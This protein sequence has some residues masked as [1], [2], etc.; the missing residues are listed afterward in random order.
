MST[1]PSHPTNADPNSDERK[2]DSPRESCGFSAMIKEEIVS[3]WTEESK[4]GKAAATT[5]VAH[6]LA[7]VIA[8][9]SLAVRASAWP[10]ESLVI[11]I[12]L[13]QAIPRAHHSA[14]CIIRRR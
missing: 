7:G 5:I 9:L 6:R 3:S 4:R 12:T 1:A 10:G 14:R 2:L 11:L 8:V 13:A